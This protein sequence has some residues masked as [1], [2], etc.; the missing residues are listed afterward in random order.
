MSMNKK[1]ELKNKTEFTNIY[2]SKELQGTFDS[3]LTL[4]LT[5]K[6]IL[7]A[8]KNLRETFGRES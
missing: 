7:I 8:N 4:A 5:L 1:C 3:T 2:R 6:L